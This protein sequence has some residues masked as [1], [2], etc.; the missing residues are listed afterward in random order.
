MGHNTV[1]DG[2]NVQEAFCHLKGWYRAAS[3]MQ[4]KLCYHTLERLNLE[5][6]DL[7]AGRESPGNPL[8]INVT[9]VVIIDDVPLDSELRQ[10][11]GKLTNSQAVGAS[12]MRAEHVREWLHGVQWEED[13]EGHG[14][15]G[16]GDS[17]R[18]FVWLAQAAWAHSTIPHQ[19]L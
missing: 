2:G 4:A 19:L 1:S 7:Y 10:V 5:W 12:G 15:D 9:Q 13:P 17:W 6:V 18:L 3:E 14:V 11:V 16:A 8:P